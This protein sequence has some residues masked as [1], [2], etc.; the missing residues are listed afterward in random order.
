MVSE[1]RRH[2]RGPAYFVMPGTQPRAIKRKARNNLGDSRANGPVKLQRTTLDAFFAPRQTVPSTHATEENVPA[3]ESLSKSLPAQNLIG[4]RDA[5]LSAE[6][7]E[8]LRLVVDDERNI[9]FTGSAGWLHD[10][11]KPGLGMS[12]DT[13]LI[14]MQARANHCF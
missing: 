7:E 1:I 9:F 8:V 5:S 4:T 11:L 6:Q 13:M 2:T 14:I 3:K 12:S 10:S